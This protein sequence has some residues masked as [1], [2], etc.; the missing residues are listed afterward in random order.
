LTWRDIRFTTKGKTLF[1]ISHGWP[2]GQERLLTIGSLH[3]EQEGIG[4]IKSVSLLGH[5]GKRQW[6]QDAEGLKI[7]LPQQKPCDYAVVFEIQQQ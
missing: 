6:Q 1:A 7:Q 5:D 2:K 4:A 3:T